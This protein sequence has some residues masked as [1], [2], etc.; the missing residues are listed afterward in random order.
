MRYHF[1]YIVRYSFQP[2]V[3][4]HFFKLRAVPCSNECQQLV[5]HHFRV[6][7]QCHLSMGDD[8]WGNEVQWGSYDYEHT[9]F[10]VCSQGTVLQTK[11]YLLPGIA[12]PYYSAS[13]R[14]TA[15]TEPML[16][17]AE[18]CRTAGELMHLVHQYVAYTPHSTTTATTA[19][20]IFADPRGVCQDYAHL[21][22]ALCRG[23][24]M[25]ARYVNGLIEGEGETHA[26]VEVNEGGFWRPYDPTHDLMPEYGYIKI[27][28]GRDADDCASNRGR[29]Y[30]HT[31]EIQQVHCVLKQEQ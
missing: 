28:H 9:Y 10:E 12:A 15:C 18:G 30:A 3:C 2:S 26:W 13:T 21:M 1:C 14:L 16:R 25:P 11:P 7:P 31:H 23:M 5:A 6:A 27:A 22:I 19:E 24:G 20:E 17:M 29:L 4:W 8:A